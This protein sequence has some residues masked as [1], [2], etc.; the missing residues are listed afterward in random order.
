[1]DGVAGYPK[2]LGW[3]AA[4]GL[5]GSELGLGSWAPVSEGPVD[6]VAT[7]S[8]SS[9]SNPNQSQIVYRCYINVLSPGRVGK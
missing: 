6:L 9:D 7:D 1:M 3:G 5:S 2:D 8:D 4:L